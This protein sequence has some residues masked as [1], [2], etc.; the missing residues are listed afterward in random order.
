MHFTLF[1]VG[2]TLLAVFNVLLKCSYYAVITTKHVAKMIIT[3]VKGGGYD[4][5]FVYLFGSLPN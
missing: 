2:S 4:N 1:M 3:S 5:G